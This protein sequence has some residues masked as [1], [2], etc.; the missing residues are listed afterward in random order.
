MAIA[1]MQDQ[2]RGNW[3][4]VALRGVAAVIFGVLA[5]LWPGV[6][7]VVLALFWGA[8]AFADGVF[9][10]IAG[11]RMR[12]HGKPMWPFVLIGIIGIL[13]GVVTF[14]WPG[15]TVVVLMMF[16]AA[17]AIIMG[18]S[19][20][21]GAIRVR[22]EINNEWLLIVS[23]ALSVTFGLLMIFLPVASAMAL[24]WLIATYAIVFGVMLI[25]LALRLR[26]LGP[27]ASGLRRVA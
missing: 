18:V 21:V 1:L 12:D 26:R 4:W 9:S 5:F 27:G 23:G 19:Q 24:V 6:T 15:I 20:I 16:I 8:Y 10:L 13:A 25:L 7:L 2:L 14:L 11:F 22:K 3:G 17:W